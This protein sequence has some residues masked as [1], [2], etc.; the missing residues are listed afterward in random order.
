MEASLIPSLIS[1][2]NFQPDRGIDRD[3]HMAFSI[4]PLDCFVF[5]N[6]FK[7]FYKGLVFQSESIQ[8]SSNS[9]EKEAAGKKPKSPLAS[10]QSW[11]VWVYSLPLSSLSDEYQGRSS[12]S[13]EFSWRVLLSNGVCRSDFTELCFPSIIYR[14]VTTSSAAAVAAVV[15]VWKSADARKQVLTHTGT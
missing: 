15:S 4:W 13:W 2:D 5:R 8:F 1:G 6:F 9:V 3:R 12:L 14:V 11:K 10:L 7:V